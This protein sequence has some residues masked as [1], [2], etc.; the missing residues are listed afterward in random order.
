MRNL[1]HADLE[2]GRMTIRRI[3]RTCFISALLFAYACTSGNPGAQGSVPAHADAHLVLTNAAIYTVDDRRSWAEAVAIRGERIVYVGDAAGAHAFTSAATRVVDLG[4]R[5]LLPGF[6]DAHVHPVSAG[7]AHVQC[8]LHGLDTP[9]ALVAKVA[10][11]AAEDPGLAWIIGRGWSLSTFPPDGRPDK[12]LLD[13]V[14]ADRPVALKSVDGHSLWVNSKALEAA[15]IGALTP[16][17]PR[18][19]IDRIPG[20]REPSG[21][22][23]ED[24]EIVLDHAPP[25]S[26]AIRLA[27]LRHSVAYLNGLG[28]TA[29]Q[30]ANVKLAAGDEYTSFAAYRA[31]DD[32]G[33]LSLRVRAAMWWEPARGID[34]QIG[35]LV[36]ARSGHTRGNVAAEAVKIMQ[37]GVLEA[38]TAAL[39]EPYLDRDDGFAG[40]L[41]VDPESLAEIVTRLDAEGFQIHYHAI[42]DRAIRVS[43]DAVAAARAANG[44]R[45]ARHH[46]SHVQLLHPQDLPRLAPLGV[47]A[48]FQPL[49][50]VTD[51]YIT[52]LTLPRI[53]A[54][55]G[56]YLYLHESVRRSGAR[57]AFGS[58]WSVS[59]PDPL[60]GIET[61]VTRLE[62]NGATS[63]PLGEGE[64]MALAD[65]IASYT[66]EAAFVNFLD[67]R[68]G[69]IEVGKLA[70]LVVLDRNLFELSADRISEAR[71][72]ATL[73]GGRI[74]HGALD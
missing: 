35:E 62:P 6:Q 56:R 71:V 46:I 41:N 40:I 39:L 22:V 32:A 27:G 65:A 37:D 5:M 72:V 15:G 59:S 12:R 8:P 13:A 44:S 49:W 7:V 18:G 53:G 14:V 47:V 17:P 28:I 42:G 25:V 45:D 68:T 66:R 3:A 48:T 70:D 73:F 20:T 43:L 34:E 50:A 4:G 69:T 64:E 67:D 26:D 58:D 51:A 38:G 16:D 31:L 10:R 1:V 61:A 11:C 29:I 52:E 54:E 63:T 2:H 24:F 30:D 36:A 21:S 57:V 33:A 19:V 9:D 60:Q 74:V 23:Q 55:R